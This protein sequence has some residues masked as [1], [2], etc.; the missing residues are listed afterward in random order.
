[1]T[2]TTPP[3]RVGSLTWQT[4]SVHARS[5]LFDLYGDHF[6]AR[7]DEAPVAALVR[8]LEA[9]RISGPAT[10]TAVS[11]M[12]GQ[13]WLEPLEL[14]SG[15]GY[16]L[17]RAAANRLDDAYARVYRSGPAPWNGSWQLVLVPPI[18]SRSRRSRVRSGLSWAG[19]GEFAD[20]VWVSPYPR[21]E[22][23][24]LLAAEGLSVTTAVAED[25]RPGQPVTAWDLE[26][27]GKDYEGFLHDAQR[28]VSRADRS[29]DDPDE[30]AFA[31]RFEM[32][33]EYRKF[34]FRDPGLPDEL[35]PGDWPGREAHRWFTEQ[36]VR[37]Y[38]AADRFVASCFHSKGN[39]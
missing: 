4:P 8:I 7:G 2:L 39:P 26:A 36:A 19:Y 18:G 27:L 21:A 3:T 1:V 28:L 6:R 13:G 9:V 22:L 5:A 35:V 25:F 24:A 38:P 30:G 10:R 33:H 20:G 23:E 32:V 12:T 16:R 34:L 17:T 14:P 11:R 31:A 15:R 29:H 37:L